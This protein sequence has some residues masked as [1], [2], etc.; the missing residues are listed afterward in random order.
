MRASFPPRLG[1][2][3]PTLVVLALA[4]GACVLGACSDHGPDV[5]NNA[6]KVIQPYRMHGTWVFDDAATGLRAEPFVQGIPEM[7]DRLVADVP[8]AEH[9]FRLT[10]SGAEFPGAT[11]KVERGDERNGGYMYRDPET[12]RQG[13][14]CPSLFRYFRE[15]PEAIWVR[16][17]ALR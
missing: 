3:P 13:W 15:A 8:D 14:L 9:G 11:L 6:I 12:G 4:L 17:D 5:R 16:A 7:I 10:F 1:V 2:R